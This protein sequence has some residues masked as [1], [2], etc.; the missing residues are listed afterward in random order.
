M[1]CFWITY[2]LLKIF[3]SIPKW[4]YI[5]LPFFRLYIHPRINVARQILFLLLLH[6]VKMTLNGCPVAHPQS[7]AVGHWLAPRKQL[8]T[9]WFAQGHLNISCWGINFARP[10]L[11]SCQGSWTSVTSRHLSPANNYLCLCVGIIMTDGGE[12]FYSKGIDDF[13]WKWDTSI[14]NQF[15]SLH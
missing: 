6:T 3:I 5:L 4:Y 10:H 13:N 9:K 11:V 14:R 12:E 2:C 8:R 15:G 7:S 1:V